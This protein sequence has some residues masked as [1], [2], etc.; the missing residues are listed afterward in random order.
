M[1]ELAGHAV[2]H[3]L[4][5]SLEQQLAE[6]DESWR[7]RCE[8]AFEAGLRR[9]RAGWPIGFCIGAALGILAGGVLAWVIA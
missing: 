9:G 3:L 2:N 7:V 8:A 6:R 4:I 1:D 5:H